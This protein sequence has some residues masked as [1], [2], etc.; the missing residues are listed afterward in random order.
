MYPS[1]NKILGRIMKKIISLQLLALLFGFSSVQADVIGLYEGDNGTQIDFEVLTYT[2]GINIDAR[3][4]PSKDSRVSALQ[5]VHMTS[6]QYR[7]VF[8]TNKTIS[9]MK[10]SGVFDSSAQAETKD[11]MRT[12]T[13]TETYLSDGG[14]LV[15]EKIL[16]IEIQ[17]KEISSIKLQTRVRRGFL[18]APL[19]MSKVFNEKVEVTKVKDGLSLRDDGYEICRVTS[20]EAID[21]GARGGSTA[22]L[23]KV[24]E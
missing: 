3:L 4:D 2:R 10:L 1:V 9:N 6:D 5:S 23:S 11:G 21:R 18:G 16:K 8:E 12:V 19:W 13:I 15:T 17:Q 7:E 14:V 22:E 20:D 24:C